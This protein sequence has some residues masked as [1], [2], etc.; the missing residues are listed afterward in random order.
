MCNQEPEA[1]QLIP[2]SRSQSPR[3]PSLHQRQL[4]IVLRVIQFDFYQKAQRKEEKDYLFQN[5]KNRPKYCRA[6]WKSR[7]GQ[8][9]PLCFLKKPQWFCSQALVLFSPK[10]AAPTYPLIQLS[11]D[12]CRLLGNGNSDSFLPTHNAQLS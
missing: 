8:K 1:N 5:Q 7:G 6:L 11:C 2:V 10:V 4:Q 9:W 12:A 3:Q